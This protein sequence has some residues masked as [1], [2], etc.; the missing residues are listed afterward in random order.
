MQYVG[1]CYKSSDS[2]SLAVNW[3]YRRDIHVE[4]SFASIAVVF[5]SDEGTE[6]TETSFLQVEKMNGVT[7]YGV[8]TE[9]VN[10]T[11]VSVMLGV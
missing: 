10:W 4:G 7:A 8:G 11:L 3:C 2:I 9:N 5:F 1:V 6:S